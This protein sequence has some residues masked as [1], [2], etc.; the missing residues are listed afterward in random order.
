[1]TGQSYAWISRNAVSVRGCRDVSAA[2]F[3]IYQEA[4]TNV[5][6]HADATEV[7]LTLKSSAG[8]ITMAIHDNGRGIQ[9]KQISDPHSFGLMGIRERVY[10]L[11]GDVT[12]HGSE[13]MGTGVTVTIPLTVK[14]M[15][16]D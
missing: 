15:A 7:R 9:E 8:T 11:V 1:M 10:S 16:H 4:L 13:M 2:L 3:R 5:V 14:E 6:R 12:I